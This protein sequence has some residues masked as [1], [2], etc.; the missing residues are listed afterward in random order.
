MPMLKVAQGAPS[1][2]ID[3]GPVIA[4]VITLGGVIGVVVWTF[5]PWLRHRFQSAFLTP[6]VERDARAKFTPGSN[7]VIK[8]ASI[9][10]ADDTSIQPDKRG[11]KPGDR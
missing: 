10:A 1:P 9:Q 8:D 7:Q 2:R 5:Y 3:F 11:L 4:V 6:D